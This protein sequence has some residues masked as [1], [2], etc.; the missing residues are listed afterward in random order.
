MPDPLYDKIS[1]IC[2]YG[3]VKIV[4]SIEKDNIY[5]VQFHPEKSQENG[6]K[7]IKNFLDQRNAET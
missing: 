6:L 2:D 5:A 7:L 4:S 3:G 1:S